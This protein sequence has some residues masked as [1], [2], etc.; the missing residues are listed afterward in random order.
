MQ[1]DGH[2]ALQFYWNAQKFLDD[3]RVI[4]IRAQNANEILKTDVEFNSKS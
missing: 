2:R 4:Q 3:L 1:F